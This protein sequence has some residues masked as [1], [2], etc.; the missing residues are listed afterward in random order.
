MVEQWPVVVETEAQDLQEFLSEY[1]YSLR[2]E[3]L[4]RVAELVAREVGVEFVRYETWDALQE[5]RCWGD[6]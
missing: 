5:E 4:R 2:G 6:G 3:A 1:K